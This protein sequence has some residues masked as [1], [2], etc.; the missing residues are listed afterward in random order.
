VS[1]YWRV[2]DWLE[3]LSAWQPTRPSFADSDCE[4]CPR[5]PFALAIDW[6][7]GAP[8]HV[9]HPLVVAIEREFAYAANWEK[10]PCAG[11]EREAEL[12]DRHDRRVLDSLLADFLRHAPRIVAALENTVLPR[13]EQ[14]IA[15]QV[16]SVDQ[17]LI[18]LGSE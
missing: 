13:I 6:P 18:G 9:Y 17:E 3:D 1:I 11:R 14:F 15:R 7:A 8:H 4:T 12:E 2:R 16:E 10:Q 5:S